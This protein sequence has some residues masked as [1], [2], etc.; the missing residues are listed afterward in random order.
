MAYFRKT[1]TGGW[2]AE[3]V[4]KGVRTSETFQRK[5]EAEAWAAKVEAD[6]LAGARGAFPS[7]TLADALDDY[8]L[9]VS[10]QKRSGHFEELRFKALKRDFPDLAGKVMHK[11][12]TADLAAWRDARLEKVSGSTVIRE[13]HVLRHV[14]TV[15]A[16]E[17][18]WC[19][20]PGPWKGLRMPRENKPRT[21]RVPWTEVKQIC[22]WA[23]LRS[24]VAPKTGQGR[25]AMA[26]LVA[27]RTAMRAGEVVGLELRDVDLAKRVVTLRRHKTYEI[28]GE[29]TVPVTKQAARLLGVMME[30][31]KS[32]GRDLL[33]DMSPMT[34]SVSFKKLTSMCGVKGLHFHDSRGEALTIL[35]KRMDAMRL[36]R[37]SG[38]R[39]INVL[40]NTYYRETAEQVAAGL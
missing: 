23:G 19:E 10:S 3:V 6:I 16:N 14:W 26:F 24:G 4:R 21:R 29:R 32:A 18:K 7:K 39:D 15:A 37:I 2:R 13:S 9:K 36:A 8:E 35:S 34:L 12:T 1:A 30:D 25:A 5:A 20:E 33:F 22:R 40:L 27:L 31:A 17:W 28:V 38:H 11:I